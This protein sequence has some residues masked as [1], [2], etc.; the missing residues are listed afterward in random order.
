MSAA[1]NLQ[2]QPAPQMWDTRDTVTKP[3]LAD[4]TQKYVLDENGNA[5]IE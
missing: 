3:A 1:I 2:C 4:E 5:I